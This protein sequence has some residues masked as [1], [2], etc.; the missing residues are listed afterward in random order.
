MK[1][2]LLI[3][4]LA[5][6]VAAQKTDGKKIEKWTLIADSGDGMA[7]Y[8]APEST[9]RNEDHVIGWTRTD[10]Q[11]GTGRV[12]PG[13]NYGSLRIFAEFDCGQ[14]RVKG[15]DILFYDV[16]GRLAKSGQDRDW[17][18]EKPGTFSYAIFEYLCERRTQF[19]TAPPKL[20][21]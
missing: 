14:N 2:L 17:S 10:F 15:R 4:A 20:K 9:R 5:F 7:F 13:T 11:N 12:L 8:F 1:A 6:T 19:P 16:D 18:E 3:L 21:P